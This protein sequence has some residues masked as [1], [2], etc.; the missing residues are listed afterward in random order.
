MKKI[1]AL[2][3]A[4]LMTA[5][6]TTVAFAAKDDVEVAIVKVNGTVVI[7]KNDDNLFD[8]TADDERDIADG[9]VIDFVAA[10]LLSRC[11]TRIPAQELPRRTMLR[12]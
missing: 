7:D 3:L 9:N 2:A 4:A 1:F 5:G 6:M 11:T 8:T 10:R 12:V